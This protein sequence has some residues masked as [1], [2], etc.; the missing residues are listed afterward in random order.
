MM[1]R[2]LLLLALALA[3]PPRVSASEP[4]SRRLTY[5]QDV[6]PILKA[7]CFQ[8]HGEE[9][10]PK[11]KLDLRLVRLMK[12]GGVSG[13]ALV[14]GNH[15]ESFLWQRIDDEEMPPLDKKLSAKDKELIAAWIDQG[16]VTARPEPAK[17]A[18]GVEP[19]DEEKAFWSF[20]PIRRTDPPRVQNQARVRVPIDAF[21]LEP[22]EKENLQFAPEADKRTLIRRVTFTLTGLPPTPAEVDRFL[23]DEDSNAYER[24]VDRLLASPRYGERWARHWLDV[25]GYADSDGYSAKDAE[26]KYAYKYRDYLVRSL[27]LDRPWDTLIREQLAGDEMLTPPYQDLAPDAVDKLVATGFLRMAPDGSSDPEAEQALARNDTIAETIKIVSTSLLGLTVGCAQ[28]HAH[29][30]D[31][32]PADDYY[33][34]RALFEPA[35]NPENWRPPA[36]RLVSLW[37]A[38]ERSRAA[39]VD[40]E[41][42]AIDSERAKALAVLVQKV[43]DQELAE[44]PEELRGELREARDTP[45]AKRTAAQ[46]QWLKTYPRLNVS[47]GN[48]SL[49][50]A[51]AFAALTKDF[52]SQVAKAREK[53]PAEDFVHAL[54]EVPGQI[55]T[56][57]LFFRGDIQQPRQAVQPGELVVLTAASETPD[58]PVD[59]PALPTSGRRLA[60]ARHLTNG[61]HPLVARVLV[62]RVWLH[63]FGR[64]IVNT[65]GDFGMLGDRPSH[66]ALLDWLADEFMSN[67]WSLKKL[68]RLILT[69]TAYRQSSRREPKLEAIDPDDRLFGRMPVRRLEAEAVRDAML[70][71]SGQLTPTMYGP[72][73]PVAIDEAGQVIVG[74]DN[75]DA[76]GRPVS[77][78]ASLGAEEWRRSLY[79]QVRRSLP[80]GLLETFDAPPMTPN[81]ERR[82]SSTVAPQSLMMMNNDFVVQQAET[83]AGRVAHEAGDAPKARVELAWRLAL[84]LEP[85][86]EQVESAVRFLADQQADFAAT[87]NAKPSKK[88]DPAHQALATFCQALFSSNA[89]L[90]VD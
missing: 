27:N 5:E 39:S 15:Q 71:V 64:G 53:R 29:R 24:L 67:G 22:L 75:R 72:P 87:R 48:V 33:R 7:H 32:I 51:K 25:A 40:T 85:A 58:I 20:Q 14:P 70:A 8:C 57:H 2:W 35:Y 37:T 82:T 38:D 13:E 43:F 76:A 83:F 77:Q 31:P 10:K 86:P 23:T 81:C 59:D 9:E 66:P 50:D 74:I 11:G 79:I 56:T 89:F 34:F 55:P 30:Y 44:A 21:L 63:H 68:H 41:V 3:L 84:A 62:N 80:L 54:T 90:Y 26:R 42:K 46:K 12:Q 47:P 4:E 19:T 88:A 6:R 60:Y 36:A 17:L 65:P 16:A 73:V 52:A 49:Y 28:C 18:P 78:R 1:T 69:S 45:A 61:K